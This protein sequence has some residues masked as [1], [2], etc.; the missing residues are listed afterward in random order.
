VNVRPHPGTGGKLFIADVEDKQGIEGGGP[1][2]HLLVPDD[3]GGYR[4]PTGEELDKILE[5]YM[6]KN[7]E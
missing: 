7:K 5:K 4:R 6:R 3:N 1:T 2:R